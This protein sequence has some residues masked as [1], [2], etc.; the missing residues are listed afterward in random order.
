MIAIVIRLRCDRA[1]CSA[2]F[3]KD[4]ERGVDQVIA[5]ARR[6]GWTRHRSG[7]DQPI[8]RCPRHPQKGPRP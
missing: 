2:L 4:A 3:A 8:D 5:E 1:G 6:L 7:A